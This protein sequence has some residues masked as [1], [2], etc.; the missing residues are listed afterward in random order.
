MRHAHQKGKPRRHKAAA[1]ATATDK[2][3]VEL[4]SLIAGYRFWCW[5]TGGG[6]N[7]TSTHTHTR[8]DRPERERLRA[9]YMRERERERAKE[10]DG[11]R[12]GGGE[13]W[14]QKKRRI[15]HLNLAAKCVSWAHTQTDTA[16]ITSDIQG[17]IPGGFSCCEAAETF[18]IIQEIT[19]HSSRFVWTVEKLMRMFQ[20]PDL[21]DTHSMPRR[22]RDK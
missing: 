6:R 4:Q 12:T 17:R 19:Y 3:H 15:Y 5:K 10:Q 20:I 18:I 21:K 16:A 7:E 8:H 14:E 2:G 22:S 11:K 9:K 13:M 1:A